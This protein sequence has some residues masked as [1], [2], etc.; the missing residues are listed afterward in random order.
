ML[1][2][3]ERSL[4]EFQE[5]FMTGQAYDPNVYLIDLCENKP[6]KEVTFIFYHVIKKIIL[7]TKTFELNKRCWV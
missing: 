7:H 1:E 4:D 6:V 5:A 2:D 3:V